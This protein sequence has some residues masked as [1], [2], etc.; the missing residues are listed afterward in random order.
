MKNYLL[1]GLII[2]SLL[3]VIGC[4]VEEDSFNNPYSGTCPH[5]QDYED[6]TGE[7]G[8]FID[9]NNDGLCDRTQ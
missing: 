3:F 5:G 1:I 2:F 9:K 8:S 6:C 7:C 4:S